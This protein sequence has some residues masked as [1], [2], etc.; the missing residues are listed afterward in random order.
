MKQEYVIQFQDSKGLDA[1]LYWTGARF[2]YHRRLYADLTINPEMARTFKY[3]SRA[4]RG[5]EALRNTT[6]NNG[7][8]KIVT[9]DICVEYK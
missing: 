8:Y 9:R 5:L 6:A 7:I 1:P 3:L 4:E 2:K